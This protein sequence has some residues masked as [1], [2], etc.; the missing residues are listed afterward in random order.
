VKAL[1]VTIFQ[2]RQKK[3]TME[4]FALKKN[5]QHRHPVGKG[6]FEMS[7]FWTSFGQHLCGPEDV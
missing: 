5:L 3:T 2:N 7:Q 1:E 6:S 4:M